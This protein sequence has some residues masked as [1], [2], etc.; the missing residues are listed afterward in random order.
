M[1]KLLWILLLTVP[2]G[3]G[4]ACQKEHEDKRSRRPNPETKK[5]NL[6]GDQ[7]KDEEPP[8]VFP[9]GG[10][11]SAGPEWKG[12]GSN[13][14][15]AE[16]KK[17]MNFF[18]LDLPAKADVQL[19]SLKG[20]CTILLAT[21][22][23][24]DKARA[25][26]ALAEDGVY[27]FNV[28]AEGSW[29]IKPYAMESAAPAPLVLSGQGSWLSEKIVKI[30]SP[31][32]LKSKVSFTVPQSGDYSRIDVTLVDATTGESFSYLVEGS[33]TV[34]DASDVI[35]VPAGSYLIAID[36]FGL[37][38]WSAEFSFEDVP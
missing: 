5:A 1:P 9:N 32:Q 33:R 19:C 38:T 24:A 4:A 28:D 37:G 17:G 14:A 18:S 8:A 3:F 13:V 25:F 36:V 31:K 15:R 11:E 27:Y 21:D 35:D 29:S 7:K 23:K 30:D 12:E 2:I 22:I 6:D 16:L 10:G 26:V 20:E 34:V